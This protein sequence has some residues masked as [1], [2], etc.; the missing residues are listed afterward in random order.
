MRKCL[1]VV[2]TFAGVSPRPFRGFM[3][4]VYVAGK[5]CP[6]WSF[7]FHAPER[8]SLVRAM[9]E[10]GKT[11]LEG[12]FDCLITFDD[13]CFPPF[14]TIPRLLKHRDD[15]R[16]FVAGVGV[17]KGYPHTT[18]IGRV[19][20]EGYSLLM[21][22][23]GD[24]PSRVTRHEWL[25]DVD[26]LGKLPEVDFCGVPVALIGREAFE[27]MKEPWFSLI[28]EDGGQVTHDVFLCRRL[29]AAGIPVLVD[30]TIKCGH[31]AD[32]PVITFE[33]RA[34]VREVKGD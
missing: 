25:D 12:G 18:T 19:F 7:G 17:M 30:T 9:T 21:K 31:M 15:G 32:P 22:K 3:E 2:P 26:K 24:G 34:Y 20:P 6:G 27:Q 23:E 10:A 33:N 16:V 28:A 5:M 1:I 4:M 29:K 13:D 14:D 11:T 8:Q